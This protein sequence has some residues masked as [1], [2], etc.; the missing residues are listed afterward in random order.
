MWNCFLIFLKNV[1]RENY[2]WANDG[3]LWYTTHIILL[4][5]RAKREKEEQEKK[6]VT[7]SI[8]TSLKGLKGA[9]KYF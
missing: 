6:K 5:E 7:Q 8:G 1:C 3:G 9:F 2:V 4:L